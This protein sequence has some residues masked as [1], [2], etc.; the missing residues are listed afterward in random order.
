MRTSTAVSLAIPFGVLG[1]AYALA[2]IGAE[3]GTPPPED[4][5][6]III[7]SDRKHTASPE[8]LAA[9][10]SMEN[11][12]APSFRAEADDGQTYSIH[13]LSREGPIALVFIKDG[14]PCSVAAGPHY[15]RLAQSYGSRIRF[16]GVIDGNAEVARK[17]SRANRVTFPILCDPDLRI[18]H[19]YHAEN[20]AYFAVIARGGRIEKYWPGYSADML[21]EANGLLARLAGAEVKPIDLTDAPT[22]LYSGCPY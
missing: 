20:S 13:D 3:F 17:W 6:V 9:A 4:D 11:R 7:S 22:E 8:M 19:E 5:P 21:N 10:G 16:F 15:S 14:C 18:V 1:V 12:A 2:R